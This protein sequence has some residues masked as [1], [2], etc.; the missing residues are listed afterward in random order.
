MTELKLVFI[1]LS[2]TSSWGNGHA[3]TYR[4][5]VRVVSPTSETSVVLSAGAPSATIAATGDALAP[6]TTY[7]REG[8]LHIWGGFDHVLFLVSLVAGLLRRP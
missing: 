6:A 1:G 2:I 3:T 5:L 8:V 4:G 7:L